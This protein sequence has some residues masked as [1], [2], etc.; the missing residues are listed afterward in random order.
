MRRDSGAGGEAAPLRFRRPAIRGLPCA[1]RARMQGVQDAAGTISGRD[2][3]ALP[4]GPAFP[5]K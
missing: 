5:I 1:A 4:P 2:G 3:R